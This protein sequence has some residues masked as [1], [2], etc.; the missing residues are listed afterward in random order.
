M[1]GRPEAVSGVVRNSRALGNAEVSDSFDIQR[2]STCFRALSV[3]QDSSL[4]LIL[5]FDAHTAS[6]HYPATSA[7]GRKVP[8]LVKCSGSCLSLVSPQLRFSIKG[9]E[10]AFIKHGLDVQ[11]DQLKAAGHWGSAPVA[12]AVQPGDES[13]A[14]GRESEDMYGTLWTKDTPKGKKVESKAGSYGSWFKNVAE[15]I[16]KKDP[17]H[18]IVKPEQAAQ[19]IE[20]IEAAGR[21]SREGKKISL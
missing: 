7:A 9:T 2:Q 20:V 6:V 15:A 3:G 19:V 8:L 18:L 13:G 21:S 11:E 16:Q 10:A 12:G 1:F 14:W 5:L 4:T 17:S